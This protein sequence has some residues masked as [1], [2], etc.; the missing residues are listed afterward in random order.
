MELTPL[1]E[2]R[3]RLKFGAIAGT[4]LIGEDF[5]LTRAMD[6]LAPIEAGSPIIGKLLQ[7]VRVILSSDCKD[8][9]AALM[10]ALSLCDA[11]LTTQG[12]VDV[13]GEM[14]PIKQNYTGSTIINIP[15]S[16]LNPL[17][18]AL[19][20]S[21][22]GRYTYIIDM[23]NEHPEYF[24]DY[25]MKNILVKA[26]GAGYYE[27]A[28]KAEEW[29]SAEGET[30]IPLLKHNFEPKG[31]KEMV[32]RIHV[33]EA[34]AK[35]KEND[36]YLSL[37]NTAAGEVK[38]AAIYALRHEQ[39]NSELL[40][41]L[42]KTQKG[43]AAKMAN[44]ALA[45]FE[46]QKALTYFETLAHKKPE[47]AAEYLTA[48]N[49]EEAG[50]LVADMLSSMLDT[51][52]EKK[53]EMPDSFRDQFQK[54]LYALTGKSGSAVCNFYK[55]AASYKTSL[56]K[57]EI[58]KKGCLSLQRMPGTY[59]H[60]S[61]SK[62]MPVILLHSIVIH[63]SEDLIALAAELFEC[64]GQ[65]YAAPYLMSELLTKDSKTAYEHAKP[66]LKNSFSIL[67]KIKGD[68]EVREMITL[69]LENVFWDNEE[70]CQTMQLCYY[71]FVHEKTYFF[72]RKLAEPMHLGWYKS[73]ES[74]EAYE[75]LLLKMIQPDNKE[76]RD[77]LLTYYKKI[78][79]K[80]ADNYHYAAA[81]KDLGFLDFEGMIFEYC[82]KRKSI[83]LCELQNFVELI[84]LSNEK[85]A[86]E[87]EQFLKKYEDNKTKLRYSDGILR[88]V[89]ELKVN[90][91]G[92]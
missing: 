64:Y 51:W 35:G 30:I 54:L 2:L 61:F 22:A 69:V 39:S 5:R 62:I 72:M 55:R 74:C 34:V 31:K 29:L 37:L 56:D 75:E 73:M 68:K 8:K 58:G 90:T 9:G 92:I 13:S 14:E 21:G 43:A 33:L 70:K 3:E 4:S 10:D 19:E 52:I 25:R 24:Q 57:I 6:T 91:V 42:T 59:R 50:N 18:D 23:H 66:I 89:D 71:D 46:N 63:P 85:K 27:L 77:F 41:E 44:W 45:G 28:M 86:A 81:L 53:E 17:Q 26:L 67:G 83:N 88:I 20:N 16:V 76:V 7:A 38:A 1:Y 82:E 48:S 12:L 65:K 80:K 84:P 79:D 40:I 49:T 15:Y 36:F 78:A 11:I 60:Y 47:H 32:R 87:L